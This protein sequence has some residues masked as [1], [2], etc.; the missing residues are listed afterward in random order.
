MLLLIDGV[1]KG[2]EAASVSV[3][4]ESITVSLDREMIAEVKRIRTAT[5]APV[6]RI[7]SRALAAY[8]RD[9]KIEVVSE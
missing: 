3:N 9:H 1:Q 4:A 6:S 2:T 8:L 7:V 5:D